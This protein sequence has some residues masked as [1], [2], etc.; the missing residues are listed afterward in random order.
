MLLYG[1][2]AVMARLRQAPA[3]FKS[4]YV[5]RHR[6]D[7]RVRDLLKLAQQQAVQVTRVEAGRLDRMAGGKRHQGVV[8]QVETQTI[9]T[10]LP[11]LLSDLEGRERPP[12]LLLLDGV[13]A[14]RGRCRGGCRDRAEG[15]RSAADRRGDAHR[16]R[17]R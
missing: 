16:Q 9:S 4:L 7:N 3:S 10:D 17:C 12:F 5:D 14:Q 11:T 6:D 1:F 13:T 2:H 15:P 8:A